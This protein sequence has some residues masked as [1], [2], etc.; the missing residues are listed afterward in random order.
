MEKEGT[1]AAALRAWRGKNSVT[2]AARHMNVSPRTW[3][4]WEQ[5]RRHPHEH[6]ML[7]ALSA[8]R[9]EGGEHG[10]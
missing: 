9:I 10:A 3:A 8:T 5:G 2:K 4:G 6:I 1:L 7:L